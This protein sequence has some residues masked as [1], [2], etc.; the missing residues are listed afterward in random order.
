MEKD[1]EPAVVSDDGALMSPELCHAA[2]R[3]AVAQIFYNAGFED[4]QPTALDAVTDLANDYFVKL[5]STLNE[6]AHQPKVPAPAVQDCATQVPVRWKSRYTAE[7]SI[8][9]TLYENG[10]DLE[11]LESYVKEDLSRATNKLTTLH[12][13]MK[14]HLADLLR[15]ALAADAG[16]DGVNAFKDGSDQFVGGDFA[17]DLEEDFFGFKELGLDKEFGLISL[18]VPLHL[19]QNRMHN[20]YQAQNQRLVS[21]HSTHWMLTDP[22]STATVAASIMPPPPPVPPVTMQSIVHEIGLAQA[23]FMEKLRKNS[24]QPLVEDD[25]LPVKQRLPK[26]RLPPT[27]KISSPRKKPAREPGPGKGHPRKKMK[28]VEGQ[29][30]V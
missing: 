9:Q 12:E 24:E 4:F 29:G 19:L 3:R 13:R 16:A 1:I 7:E 26:P 23:F 20:A 28:L 11:H 8:V 10:I 18:S 17:E 27:G 6:V 5:A 15:P 21:S 2:M 14:C 30:W 25:D 22:S